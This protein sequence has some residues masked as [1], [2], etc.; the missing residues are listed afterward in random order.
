MDML[1]LGLVLGAGLAGF[2]VAVIAFARAGGIGRAFWGLSVGGRASADPAFAAEVE[3]LM[4]AA[5]P[6]PKPVGPVKPSG[7]P[8][9]V[10]ALLQAEARLVDFLMEDI[11]GAPSP[12]IGEAVKEIHKKA[13]AALKQHV[14]IVPVLA[15]TEGEKVT[16]PVGFDPSAVRVV[17]NVTGQPPFTGELQHPGWIVSELKLPPTAAGQDLFVLQPAEVQV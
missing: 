12:Q 5:A 2:V 9:R 8:L 11:S 6:E 7:E 16:V 3:R 1:L 13:Q 17:G 15:G 10:L 4:G 14:T